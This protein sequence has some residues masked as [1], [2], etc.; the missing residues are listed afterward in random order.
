M[1][2]L[3]ETPA[4]DTNALQSAIAIRLAAC[5]FCHDDFHLNF[6]KGKLIMNH[7]EQLESA[8]V[9]HVRAT[10]F[11]THRF[12][13]ELRVRFGHFA[14]EE[15]RNVS[16]EPFLQSDQSRVRTVPGISLAHD[17]NDFAHF[18]VVRDHVNDARSILG[19]CGSSFD[20]TLLSLLSSI[21]N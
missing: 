16:V 1:G 3:C 4:C 17:E 14:V 19:F 12:T 7:A 9:G 18:R 10:N 13:N 6:L 21:L 15:K 20:V 2:L 8:R 5:L 11:Y